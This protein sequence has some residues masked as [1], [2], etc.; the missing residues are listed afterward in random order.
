MN[1]FRSAE[2]IKL[3]EYA[4][5]IFTKIYG[6]S[7]SQIPK[8]YLKLMDLYFAQGLI[9]QAFEVSALLEKKASESKVLFQIVLFSLLFIEF[10]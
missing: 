1:E 9:P 8:I 3:Y 2:A 4:G 5:F 10:K 6:K 7:H